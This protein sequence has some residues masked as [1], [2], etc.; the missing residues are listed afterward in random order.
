MIENS[1]SNTKSL[2]T[3]PATK[4]VTLLTKPR[5]ILRGVLLALALITIYSLITLDRAGLKFGEAFQSLGVNLKAMFLQPTVGQDTWALLLR[6][7]ATSVGLAMLTTLL[8]ALFAFFIAVFSARNLVPG[9]LATSIKA[10]MAFIRSIPTILWV[11]IYS[12]VMGLGANAAVVGLT[13]HSIAYLVKAYSESI[14]ETST[15]TIEALKA[16]G[17]GFWPIIFQAIL[18]SI[19]PALLSWT[20]IRFEIN[21]ANAIAVGAAA[22]ADDIGYYL[23]MASGFY[24]NFHEVGLIVYLLLGVAIVL[25]IVSMKLRG[26]Y[27]QKN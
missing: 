20:F 16:S 19:I 27:L 15:D 3:L 25:E 21:F 23:F 8:G 26:H 18:P 12:V 22:G 7:L 13:F 17:V 2:P 11:L 6:A 9:W 24:F 4:R 5:L 1:S 10:V 14:E